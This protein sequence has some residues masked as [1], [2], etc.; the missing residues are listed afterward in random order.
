MNEFVEITIK[1]IHEHIAITI[2][3]NDIEKLINDKIENGL[4]NYNSDVENL[5]KDKDFL[6][7]CEFYELEINFEKFSHILLFRKTKK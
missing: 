5:I 4:K 7:V 2:S 3:K 6:E 1:K